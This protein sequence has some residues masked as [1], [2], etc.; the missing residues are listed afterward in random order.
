[1][2]WY[3]GVVETSG[4]TLHHIWSKIVCMSI[5]LSFS[6]QF[7]LIHKSYGLKIHTLS[8]SMIGH[9]V[10]VTTPANQAMA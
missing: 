8:K 2:H 4:H 5:N 9:R 7:G 1:M 3:W 6:N 10:A